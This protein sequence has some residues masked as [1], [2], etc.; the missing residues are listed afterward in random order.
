[1]FVLKITFLGFGGGNAMLPIIKSEAVE[2]KRWLTNAEFDEMVV[3]S[4]ML[5]GPSTT[6]CLSYVVRK[7]YNIWVTYLLVLIAA[8]PHILFAFLILLILTYIP[9][10]YI[11]VIGA[12][13]LMPVIAGV[14][15]IGYR[16]VKRSQNT[17]KLPVWLLIAIASTAYCLFIPFP[18][19]LPIFTFG[20]L[21]ICTFIYTLI[22]MYK[23]K[24]RNKMTKNLGEQ[25]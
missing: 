5:P 11:Y 20:I 19:N 3:I 21:F 7:F 22:V 14:V 17:L 6:Q 4:N 8:L 1:M 15:L 16:Y 12:C 2:K 18:Y 9:R 23:H 13:A 25:K 10:Q 24:K